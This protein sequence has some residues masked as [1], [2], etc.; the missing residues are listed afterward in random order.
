MGNM[1]SP[2]KM[3]SEV[4]RYDFSAFSHRSYIELH[5][6]GGYRHNWH[7]DVLA[8]KL[9]DVRLG[10]CKR[11]IVNIPPRH[12]KS[13]VIS[14]VFPAWLLGHAPKMHIM[15]LS[16]GQEVADGFARPCRRL[17]DSPFYKAIFDTRL[18]PDHRAVADF[19][20]TVGGSR[21]STS[22][23]GVVTS[24][25]A[26]IIIIDDPIKADEAFSET[27]RKS[28]N[29]WYD[30]TLRSRLNYQDKG[31]ISIVMQRLHIDDLV[32][33]VQEHEKWDVVSFPAIAMEDTHYD[34][35]TPF[36][37]RRI[38]RHEGEVLHPEHMS[39]TAI[40]NLRE[41][42]TEYNFSAQFQQQPVAPGGNVIKIDWLKY[43]P[44]GK[45]PKFRY[46]FQSWDT[47]NKAEDW[48]AYS[49]C[50]TWGV[51]DKTRFYLL[52]V[53]RRRL[54]YPELKRAVIEQHKHY[55]NATVIIEDKASGIQL[56]QELK[57][58]Q[59]RIRP[60][61]PPS[62]TDK[63]MRLYLQSIHFENGRVFLPDRSSWLQPYVAELT[64]F[65]NSKYDDQVDSTTQFLDFINQRGS[66]PLIFTEEAASEFE[67]LSR[68]GRWPRGY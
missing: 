58:E 56:I 60:Y 51:V 68:Q 12:L 7:L 50:T 31:A 5:G 18:S 65:P 36:G 59:I 17:I 32:A 40:E 61:S 24:R 62:G 30:N 49:V 10:R 38:E 47:A 27:R 9:E 26:D 22:V 42:M 16:Y 19:E 48:S 54:N 46:Y 63:L 33:H 2:S 15:C 14:V 13:H 39:R 43:Y 23:E 35:E 4:L 21:F 44:A 37:R 29:E 34:V 28:V 66:T 45:E 55:P 41:G 6:Q 11:L 1:I 8:A 20:T 67:R 25:G 57:N 52:D 64:G 53:F 3:F